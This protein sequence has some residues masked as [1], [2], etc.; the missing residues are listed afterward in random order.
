MRGEKGDRGWR[1]LYGDTGT[2]GL[3]KGTKGG[4]GFKGD[5]G[6][7]GHKGLS[8]AK[9]ERGTPGRPG[10]K[11]DLGQKGDTGL[12]GEQ[13]PRG[14]PGPRGKMGLK[15]SRGST[16]QLGHPGLAGLPG[17]TG[18][19]G[20]PGQVYILPGL[21]GDPGGQGPSAPCTCSQPPTS[22]S[23]LDKVLMVSSVR[24][25]LELVPL[26]V[27]SG[28]FVRCSLYLTAL[29]LGRFSLQTERKRCD[30][31]GRRTPSC[32]AQ[33]EEHFTSMP[34]LSGSTSWRG[35]NPN[36]PCRGLKRNSSHFKDRIPKQRNRGTRSTSRFKGAL[37][38]NLLAC[39]FFQKSGLGMKS[40]NQLLLDFQTFLWWPL[41]SGT[42]YL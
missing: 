42:T 6:R 14:E 5:K 2:P 16:G 8:G 34:S 39:N 15:G 13:G 30:A 32:C 7:R 9:G 26:S 35:L 37:N 33:T 24:E 29:P 10:Q 1:G 36:P 4:D 12:R 21:Q 19:T 23:Q 20:L 41:V 40:T 11:G 28:K 17:L 31:C 27:R 18:A 22:Q 3:I 25:P 38:R